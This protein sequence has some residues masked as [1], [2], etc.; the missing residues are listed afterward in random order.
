M[1]SEN[2]KRKEKNN[3]SDHG[4]ALKNKDVK[5]KRMLYYNSSTRKEGKISL[6]DDEFYDD[7]KFFGLSN[8]SE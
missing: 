6:Y 8:K 1:A 7:L 3:P 4:F 5:M 2:K